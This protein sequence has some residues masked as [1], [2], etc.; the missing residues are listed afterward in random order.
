MLGASRAR[1]HGASIGPPLEP[2]DFCCRKFRAPP[3]TA[4]VTE[5]LYFRDQYLLRFDARV[6]AVVERDGADWV[7]LDRTAFY[8]EGGG[9]PADHGRLGDA[10]VVDVRTEGGRVAHRVIGVRFAPGARVVGEVDGGRRLDHMQQHSGQHLLT[11]AFLE[12]VGADTVSFHLGRESSTID[13]ARGELSAD[14]IERVEEEAARVIRENRPVV[15]TLHED[16]AT[17]PG[18]LR[19]APDVDGV[20]R[21]IEIDG[22]DRCPCGGTHVRST[23]EIEAIALEGIERRGDGTSRV[24]FLCGGRARRDHRRRRRLARDLVRLFSVG[25]GEVVAAATRALDR[26]GQA[27]RRATELATGALLA[28]V[29]GLLETADRVGDVRIL[30]AAIDLAD[31]SMLADVAREVGATGD[32]A[33]V[34]AT[35]GGRPQ[36]LCALPSG[37]PVGADRLLSDLLRPLGGS[38]GGSPRLARGGLK[39]PEDV[40]LLLPIARR[41]LLEL[42]SRSGGC[43]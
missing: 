21:V 18:G 31:R 13:V 2:A 43:R 14:E 28:R 5:R 7:I 24:E 17:F 12:V 22:Y 29:R 33:A 16:R 1:K 35:T 39:S 8:P 40:E 23:G 25:E 26:L 36:V 38:G 37:S 19:K 6:D 10:S 32:V 41:H 11:R 27:E 20:L 15:A 30:V 34:L 42:H 9:Q 4:V 3:K